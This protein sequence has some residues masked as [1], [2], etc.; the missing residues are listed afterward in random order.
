VTPLSAEDLVELTTARV[1]IEGLVLRH[2]LAEG[3]MVWESDLVARHYT[4]EHTPQYDDGDPDRVADAWSAAHGAFHTALLAGCRNTR[5]RCLAA[6][7]RDAAVL[8]Q[9]WSQQIGRHPDR[10]VIAEHRQ[11]LELALA[12]DADAAVD[13]LGRHISR[14]TEI[15]LAHPES[16]PV[17]GGSGH[18]RQEAL[19]PRV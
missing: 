13:A 19:P 15:L 9:S 7:L 14:T 2:C 18:A 1:E 11:L 8:Y 12:R 17:L 16:E 6:S 10:D 3:D 5:L 4:L